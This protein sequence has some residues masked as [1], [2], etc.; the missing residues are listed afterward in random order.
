MKSVLT[1]KQA[2]ILD[3]RS[4]GIDTSLIERRTVIITEVHEFIR[5]QDGRTL[6]GG[7]RI[8][9]TTISKTIIK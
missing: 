9:R 6:N 2:A 1:P 3:M 8:K 5:V 7:A 4:C